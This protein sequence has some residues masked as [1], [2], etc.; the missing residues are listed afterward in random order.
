VCGSYTDLST[1][2]NWKTTTQRGCSRGRHQGNS[3]IACCYQS[4]PA[5][6]GIILTE[7]STFMK[8]RTLIAPLLALCLAATAFGSNIPGPHA[9]PPLAKQPAPQALPRVSQWD[10]PY[11]VGNGYNQSQHSKKQTWTPS[12]TSHAVMDHGGIGFGPKG[13]A[14]SD[15]VWTVKYRW[16]GTGAAHPASIIIAVTGLSKA[17]GSH[18][19]TSAS[20]NGSHM[21]ACLPYF[22]QGHWWYISSFKT[23]AMATQN[24]NYWAWNGTATVGVS[25][26]YVIW[27]GVLTT[28]TTST[29]P[30]LTG[31]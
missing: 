25:D 27:N 4:V 16:L 21:L 7:R 30:V 11:Y 28:G 6:A 23:A 8:T 14:G 22:Y 26:A 29:D 19:N 10:G 24:S 31:V 9:T 5:I 13:W 18:V 17:N 15:G 1:C 20:G 2:G 3:R 12:Q